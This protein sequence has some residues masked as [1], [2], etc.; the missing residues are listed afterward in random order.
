MIKSTKMVVMHV[1]VNRGTM[2]IVHC[3]DFSPFK[4]GS[5]EAKKHIKENYCKRFNGK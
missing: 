2:R 1:Q 4:K 5:R 3:M